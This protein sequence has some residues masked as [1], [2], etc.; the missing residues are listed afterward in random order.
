MRTPGSDP[1]PA[2]LS[3]AEV[4]LR[5]GRRASRVPSP[6]LRFLCLFS[7]P[8]SLA[9][10]LAGVLDLLVWQRAGS[11]LVTLGVA[12]V[13]AGWAAA[14]V[15]VRPVATARVLRDGRERVVPVAEL[16]RDDLVLL[17]PGEVLPADL[18]I[19]D[20][21]GLVLDGG[22]V[23]GVAVLGGAGRGVVTVAPDCPPESP[24]PVPA[25]VRTLGLI[26]VMGTAVLAGVLVLRVPGEFARWLM[27]GA[28][29]LGAV[30]SVRPATVRALARTAARR[31]IAAGPAVLRDPLA[32]DR[33][34]RLSVLCLDG[35][36]LAATGV[37]KLSA[38]IP[39]P[40]HELTELWLSVL[41]VT[42]GDTG[43]PAE[44]VL[45]RAAASAVEQTLPPL[46]LLLHRRPAAY[47]RE[48]RASAHRLGRATVLTV[49]GEPESVLPCCAADERFGLAV[50]ELANGGHRVLVMAKTTFQSTVDIEEDRPPPGLEVVGLL[51]ITDAVRQ[52]TAWSV[53]ELR[54]CGVRVVLVSGLPPAAAAELAG[55]CGISRRQVLDQR[56]AETDRVARLR[57]ADVVA[58][59]PA[60]LIGELVAAHREAGEVVAVLSDRPAATGALRAAD[61]G[62][63]ARGPAATLAVTGDQPR[64]LV[65]AIRQCRLAVRNLHAATVHL[66]AVTLALVLALL[67]ASLLFPPPPALPV[68]LACLALFA[69]ALP[70]TALAVDRAAGDPF[71]LPPQ[72]F[73]WWQ[74]LPDAL[75]LAA[76]ALLCAWLGDPADA[77]TRLVLAL[78]AGSLALALVVRGERW[79]L[80]HGWAAARRT[81]L[82]LAAPLG[83]VLVLT[84]IPPLRGAFGLTWIGLDGL[85][86]VV[87]AG[88]T[89]LALTA[90]AHRRPEDHSAASRAAATTAWP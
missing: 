55:R 86:L 58:G 40:G 23:A 88:L 78:L 7:G 22:P 61:L 43:G 30:G 42:G 2:G 75:V 26:I 72:R 28:V 51:G 19:V 46:G 6:V 64:A 18:S 17:G 5:Q 71:Y 37:P 9:L 50:A 80:E 83:C 27:L 79:P 67:G 45:L 24:E 62:V 21:Q 69:L 76:V 8:P 90:L 20:N 47:G 41:R 15:A 39:A 32:V 25:A 31:R 81:P 38:V 77:A 48:W 74:A 57:Q 16:V 60:E 34:A 85:G 3:S 54:R 68:H 84:A 29:L 13:L 87:L 52:A 59:C 14:V 33:L 65:G 82:L 49:L 11:G 35:N 66:A 10:V 12:V 36:A 53:A 89:V 1:G 73:Q 63:A 44:D 70:A 56:V 4:A